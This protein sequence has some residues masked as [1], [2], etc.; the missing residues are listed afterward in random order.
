MGIDAARIINYDPGMLGIVG[1][2]LTMPSR[3][4]HPSVRSGHV[5]YYREGIV[6]RSTEAV[7]R[8]LG[9]RYNTIL[10]FYRYTVIP[11]ASLAGLPV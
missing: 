4:W 1:R 9:F 2:R 3:D 10:P 7:L 8:F 11:A 5:G 6:S